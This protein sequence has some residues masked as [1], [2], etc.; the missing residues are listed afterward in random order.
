MPPRLQMNLFYVAFTSSR[1]WQGELLPD[2]ACA[3]EE[4]QTSRRPRSLRA[5]R[6]TLAVNNIFHL[7]AFDSACQNLPRASASYRGGLTPLDSLSNRES[8]L[9]RWKQN[10]PWRTSAR[11]R[12]LPLAAFFF[13]TPEKLETEERARIFGQSPTSAVDGSM[14]HR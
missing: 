8:R 10:L 9:R 14:Y 2:P 3:S 13:S 7:A 5:A 11:P 6:R 4:R 1:P 12:E